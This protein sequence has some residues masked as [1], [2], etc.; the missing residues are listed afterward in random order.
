MI[1]PFKRRSY[2]LT[3]YAIQSF[4]I[5]HEVHAMIAIPGFSTARKASRAADYWRKFVSTANQDGYGQSF[6]NVL[7]CVVEVS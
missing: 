1:W 4:G 7:W 3:L 2:T 5:R 6:H